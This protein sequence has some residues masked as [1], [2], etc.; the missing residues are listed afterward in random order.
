MKLL[1]KTEKR[2]G[3]KINIKEKGIYEH[4]GKIFDSLYSIF[5]YIGRADEYD[6]FLA[7]CL[8]EAYKEVQEE[9]AKYKEYEKALFEIDDLFYSIPNLVETRKDEGVYRFTEDTEFTY[10]GKK[11]KSKRQ[12][13]V[14]VLKNFAGQKVGIAIQK[15]HK[16]TAMIFK[17]YGLIIRPFYER[18]AKEVKKIQII[19][20]DDYRHWLQKWSRIYFEKEATHYLITFLKQNPDIDY[21]FVFKMPNLPDPRILMKFPGLKAM[22]Y[23]N[24]KVQGVH[25]KDWLLNY[26]FYP[27]LAK[28]IYKIVCQINVLEEVHPEFLN[29]FLKIKEYLKQRINPARKTRKQ[30]LP[31]IIETEDYKKASY[32]MKSVF[33]HKTEN[34]RFVLIDR[35]S[36]TKFYYEPD[37]GYKTYSEINKFLRRN[38]IYDKYKELGI[39]I[40]PKHRNRVIQR[41]LTEQYKI[42]SEGYVEYDNKSERWILYGKNGYIGLKGKDTKFIRN[43][44]GRFESP[45]VLNKRRIDEYPSGEPSN[46]RKGIRIFFSKDTYLSTYAKREKLLYD[47]ISDFPLYYLLGIRY[48]F[49]LFFFSDKVYEEFMNIIK[50][51][52]IFK[53]EEEDIKKVF[54]IHSS[55]KYEAFTFHIGEEE[56]NSRIDSIKSKEFGDAMRKIQRL[57]LVSLFQNCKCLNCAYSRMERKITNAK[58]IASLTIADMAKKN[59]S[60]LMSY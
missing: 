49:G 20:R 5:V 44:T 26:N 60:V 27:K 53:V 2:Y 7:D 34:A 54:T 29:D 36:G 31:D 38:E 56:L 6:Y 58:R 22:L 35:E 23:N 17:K 19:T 59:D 9:T 51:N 15:I 16:G 25:V 3:I 32:L 18:R 37:R 42:F 28:D 52:A 14:Y 10:K 1:R 33:E 30:K 11:Y 57:K 12:A 39:D 24:Y 48:P 41:Y 50:A 13:R 46:Y 8:G 43:F 45:F 40:G 21:E 55:Y 47:M 4:D